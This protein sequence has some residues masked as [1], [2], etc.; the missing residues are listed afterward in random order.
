MGYYTFVYKFGNTENVKAEDR[1]AG[2]KSR[3]FRSVG[4]FTN[5]QVHIHK[6][7]RPGTTICGSHKE[8]LRAGIEPATRCTAAGCITTATTVQSKLSDVATSPTPAPTPAAAAAR[9]APFAPSRGSQRRSSQR[10]SS[11]RRSS[12]R[13][14]SQRRSSHR[15]S[16]QRRK[17]CVRPGASRAGHCRPATSRGCWHYYSNATQSFI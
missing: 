5:I 16:S 17:L 13:R 1:T 7:P 3:Y 11:Q 12:Q 6:T 10:R 14:S 8:L 15:R 2:F 4:A 9:A